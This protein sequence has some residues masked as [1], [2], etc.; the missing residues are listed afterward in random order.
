MMLSILGVA[1][2]T[3]GVV[4]KDPVVKKPLK[5]VW[6]LATRWTALVLSSPSSST[7]TLTTTHLLLLRML[8][9]MA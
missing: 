9:Q 5:P 1:K 4:S 2:T 6:A 7:A 3:D 8:S